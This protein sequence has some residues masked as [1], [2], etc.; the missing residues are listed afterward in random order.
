[1][2]PAVPLVV[3]P[4]L[5]NGQGQ[6]IVSQDTILSYQQHLFPKATIITPNIDETKLLTNLPQLVSTEDFE[7]AARILHAL[8]PKFVLIKGGQS[9]DKHIVFDVLYDGKQLAFLENPRLPVENPHGIGCTFASAIAAEI[10]KG[11]S[12]PK[13]VQIALQYVQ[14]ALAG[15]LHWTIGQGRLPLNHFAGLEII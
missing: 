10:A 9:P 7:K 11:N 14:R 5:V 13:A 3:D 2:L 1:M 8:G 4:V 6:L 15:A 12:V